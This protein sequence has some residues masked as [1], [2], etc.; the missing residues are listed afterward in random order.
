MHVCSTV[1]VE[2]ERHADPDD[3]RGRDR[4][5]VL[6]PMG[7][8]LIKLARGL[9]PARRW[10]AAPLQEHPAGRAAEGKPDAR[11][12]PYRAGGRRVL[13][14]RFLPEDVAESVAYCSH[15][16]V[17]CYQSWDALYLPARA[18]AFIRQM[19]T[20]HPDTPGNG[21]SSPWRCARSDS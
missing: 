8:F 5:L 7:A 12:E 21:S 4:W 3:R 14:L 1:P 6:I 9:L 17:A 11:C 20:A 15:A 16:E 13:V 19:M 18:S 10:P 2:N